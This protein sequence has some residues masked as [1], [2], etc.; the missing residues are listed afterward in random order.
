M[1]DPIVSLHAA[2]RAAQHHGRPDLDED[3]LRAQPQLRGRYERAILRV[4]RGARPILEYPGTGSSLQ[5]NPKR[6][7]VL[8]IVD[9]VV[10][11]EI[12]PRANRVRFGAGDLARLGQR[13]QEGRTQ[14]TGEPAHRPATVDVPVIFQ[15]AVAHATMQELLQGSKCPTRTKIAASSSSCRLRR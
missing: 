1:N 4:L 2:A 13:F 10:V 6:T 5:V 8:V 3:A 14:R 15:R 11:T 9:C 7:R 12:I